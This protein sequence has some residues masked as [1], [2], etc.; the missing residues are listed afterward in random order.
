MEGSWGREEGGWNRSERQE[1]TET[2][3]LKKREIQLLKLIFNLSIL[4]LRLETSVCNQWT[5]L[6]NTLLLII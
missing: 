5:I 2:R 1:H 3:G 4:F 6:F